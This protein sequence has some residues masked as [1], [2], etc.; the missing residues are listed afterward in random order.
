MN[1][2]GN[3][4]WDDTYPSKEIIRQDIKNR[5]L[6]VAVIDDKVVG[7]VTINAVFPPEY[8]T[9]NW[10]T[11]PNTYTFH[12]MMVS[13]KHRGEGIAN[14]LFNYIRQRGEWMGLRSI[15]VDTNEH[16]PAM[17]S[18]FEKHNY[19]QVGTVQLKGKALNYL[20]FERTI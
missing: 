10:K 6:Y 13:V 9:V 11:S 8:A 4:Q 14:E 1:K 12:R 20:C 18:L 16:N 7:S 5:H 19:S 2:A 3:F 17:I 15:R